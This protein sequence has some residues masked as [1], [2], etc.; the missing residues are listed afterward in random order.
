VFNNVTLSLVEYL[1]TNFPGRWIGRAAP[2]TW[3]PRSP[4]PTSLDV[5][6]WRF[7]K[8]RMFI[9]IPPLSA[10]SLSCELELL[11]LLQKWCQRCYLAC[12]KKLTT[13]GTS[14]SLP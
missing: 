8:D 2:I 6:L 14:A 11:P 5:F 9:F 4:D 10:M 7:V 12:G 13:G 1:S 3:P